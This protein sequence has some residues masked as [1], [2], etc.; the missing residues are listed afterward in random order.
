[1]TSSDCGAGQTCQDVVINP[2]Y[3][4]PCGACAAPAKVC[5]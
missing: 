5:L 1:V 3:N 4:L 2:C